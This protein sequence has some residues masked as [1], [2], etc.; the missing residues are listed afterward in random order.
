MSFLIGFL[1]EEIY[2]KQPEGFVDGSDC[3]CRLNR[4][5]YGLKQTRRNW[6]KRFSDCFML[7]GFEISEANPCLFLK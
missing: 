1:D 5:L 4:S 7:V 2:M 3:I 6:N